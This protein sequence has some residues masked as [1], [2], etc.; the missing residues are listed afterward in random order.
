MGAWMEGRKGTR[1]GGEGR[2]MRRSWPGAY[3]APSPCPPAYIG[4]PS[5]NT[6]A[7]APAV[8]ASR[9]PNPHIHPAPPTPL[10]T[11]CQYSRNS[12]DSPGERTRSGEFWSCARCSGFGMPW[13]ILGLGVSGDEPI[14]SGRGQLFH[15]RP[16]MGR[17]RCRFM[18]GQMSLPLLSAA[19]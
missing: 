2:G 16:F 18:L 11:S 15:T 3:V 8:T 6:H 14:S 19:R 13:V 1:R 12:T 9:S 7:C 4:R 10:F 17:E 5:T